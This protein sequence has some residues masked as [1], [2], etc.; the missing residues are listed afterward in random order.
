MLPSIGRPF[1]LACERLPAVDQVAE[2]IS[3]LA[4]L[5]QTDAVARGFTESATSET[6]AR[7]LIDLKAAM[8][9]SG[10]M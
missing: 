9:Q 8:V 4:R 3:T 6:P 2:S 10:R 1:A 7:L 5:V